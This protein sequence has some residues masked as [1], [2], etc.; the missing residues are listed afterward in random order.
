LVHAPVLRITFASGATFLR[1]A[2]RPSDLPIIRN[3]PPATF[4]MLPGLRI[5]LPTDQIVAV[6]DT[7]ARVSVT[8]GGFRFDGLCGGRLTFSRLRDL[9]PESELS[10]DRSWTMLLDP[11]WV[12]SVDQDDTRVFP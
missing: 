2:D 5:S 10:P 1:E 9:R 11:A 12:E 3:G 6:D 7:A 8:F 4:V